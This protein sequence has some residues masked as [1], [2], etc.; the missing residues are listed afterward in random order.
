[1]KLIVQNNGNEKFLEFNEL[2]CGDV[3][4]IVNEGLNQGVIVMRT[5][6]NA[7]EGGD[8]LVAIAT[9]AEKQYAQGI[10]AAAP[11]ATWATFKFRL[12]KQGTTFV[13][14]E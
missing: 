11:G 7:G 8:L 12:L 13:V 4:E 3:A 2:K 1:M 5:W 10:A 6:R 9:L 14:S